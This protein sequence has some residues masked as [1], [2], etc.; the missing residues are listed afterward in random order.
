MADD[1]YVAVL[2]PNAQTKT[3]ANTAGIMPPNSPKM[4]NRMGPPIMQSQPNHCGLS[5]RNFLSSGSDEPNAVP[6]IRRP[7]NASTMPST[8][9]MNP[10]PILA[11]VPNLYP[12][13]VTAAPTPSRSISPPA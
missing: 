3:Q 2:S 4:M 7:R 12:L 5:G 6:A 8:T 13:P 1:L 9:G 10:G 11:R